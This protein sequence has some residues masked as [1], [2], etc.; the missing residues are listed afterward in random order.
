VAP[1]RNEYLLRRRKPRVRQIPL[2]DVL[3]ADDA[4]PERIADLR[5]ILNHA[6]ALHVHAPDIG[7]RDGEHR[8]SAHAAEPGRVRLEFAQM[9]EDSGLRAS[10][11]RRDDERHA[12]ERDHIV[13]HRA[14]MLGLDQP[15]D[16]AQGRRSRHRISEGDLEPRAPQDRCVPL[17][18]RSTRVP[19]DAH[20]WIANVHLPPLRFHFEIICRRGSQSVG[21]GNFKALFEGREIEQ[22]RRGNL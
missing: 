3:A 21:K 10:L 17:E 11:D 22:E 14:R 2:D 18:Q 9:P 13:L 12:L 19:I 1:P 6:C 5:E 4:E 8:N 16:V 7:S 15:A 20:T